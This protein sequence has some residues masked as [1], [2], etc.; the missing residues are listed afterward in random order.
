MAPD[1]LRIPKEFRRGQPL[2]IEVDGEPVQA[3]EGETIATALLASG[4]RFFRRTPDGSPRGLYCGMGICF[5]CVV[6]VDGES[7]V[8]SCITL[9]RPG[10]KVRTPGPFRQEEA[11]P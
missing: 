2:R 7:S 9:V 8:R 3:F 1:D 11:R 6:E 4:R 5:D 10:M